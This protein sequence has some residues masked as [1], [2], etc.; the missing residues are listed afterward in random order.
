MSEI[1]RVMPDK[2]AG[3]SKEDALRQL[4]EEQNAERKRLEDLA[5]GNASGG[6][7]VLP[8]PAVAPVPAVVPVQNPLP[9]LDQ[10]R[11]NPAG[12]PA[13]CL[14]GVEFGDS[15]VD[16]YL[17]SKPIELSLLERCLGGKTFDSWN[18]YVDTQESPHPTSAR[19]Y[20]AI[21]KALY[22]HKDQPDKISLI[23]S[24]RDDL[25][26][27]INKHSIITM[28]KIQRQGTGCAVVAHRDMR[29]HGMGACANYTSAA[30]EQCILDETDRD[31]VKE[32]YG[33]LT[34]TSTSWALFERL[35]Y[36]E[37]RIFSIA[38]AQPSGYPMSTALDANTKPS[39]RGYAIG[40]SILKA[41]P[42]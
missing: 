13:Y 10:F 20:H 8:V 19:L 2:F 41:E 5:R 21:F 3:F 25:R 37:K 39:K 4:E 26:S 32:I 16:L 22:M 34:G 11:I 28:T 14:N 15:L 17:Y 24:A 36:G 29:S 18:N 40:V 35:D 38:A 23:E 27:I 1:H 31:K 33:W 7:V 6:K 42:K 12:G 9:A 30:P